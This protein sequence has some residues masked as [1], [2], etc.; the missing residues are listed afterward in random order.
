MENKRIKELFEGAFSKYFSE[1]SGRW[2][3]EGIN[4]ILRGKDRK[5]SVDDSQVM[6]V[7]KQLEDEGWIRIVNDKDLFLIQL[8]G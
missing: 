1:G 4:G 7:L 2:T 5:L 3:K 6:Q 8:K